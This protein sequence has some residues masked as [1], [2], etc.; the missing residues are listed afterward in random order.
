MATQGA[1]TARA[2][3]A[4]SA[5]E[6]A[7]TTERV[8]GVGLISGAVL[9]LI[10]NILH[11]RESFT[12]SILPVQVTD[13]TSLIV[14]TEA[15][16]TLSH[17][18][19]LLTPVALTLGFVALYRTLER[20]GAGAYALPGLVSVAAGSVMFLSLMVLDGFVKQVQAQAIVSASGGAQEQ[21]IAQFQL[22]DLMG[23]EYLRFTFFGL[24]IGAGLF[25]AGILR[26]N[27]YGRVL[28]WIGIGLAALGLAGY[29][30]G[31]F[32]PYWV[33]SPLFAPYAVAFTLWFLVLGVRAWRAA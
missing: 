9:L 5:A 23:A 1:V 21:L 26:V 32:A 30:A 13:Y 3:P 14:S 33:L 10:G 2:R 28:G 12:G 24:W 17:V 8:A 4:A 6:R 31:I 25:A 16:Y 29:A 18:A 22:V 7:S 20:S 27:Q 11:P 19:L 15:V